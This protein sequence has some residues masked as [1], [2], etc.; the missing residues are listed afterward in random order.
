MSL[1]AQNAAAQTDRTRAMEGMVRIPAGPFLMGCASGAPFEHPVHEVHLSEF[2]LDRA[3]VNNAQFAQFVKSS[4]YRTTAEEAGT[5]WG[6]RDGRFGD[7]EDLCWREFATPNRMDHPVVLVSWFD[8]A[9]YAAWAGKRLPTEAEWEKA[10]RGFRVNADYPW[11]D[12]PPRNDD[13][14]WGAQPAELPPT[15]PVGQGDPNDYGLHDLVGH[16]W[17]WCADWFGPDYYIQSPLHDPRGPD[18]GT[19]R[20]RRGGAWN[21]IQPFRLRCANRGAMDP[22]AAAPN[23]GFRCAR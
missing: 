9:A 8:A 17:Q 18:A 5:A 21:V 11:G 13:A 6:F 1:A 20:I 15:V 22:A 14:T 3:V 4:G 7:I 10:S 12:D 23:V 16:V 2:W 19:T